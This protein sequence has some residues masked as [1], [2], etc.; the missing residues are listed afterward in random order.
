MKILS[1][2]LFFIFVTFSNL[3]FAKEIYKIDSSH[4]SVSWHANHFGFSKPSGKFSDVS[5]T[6]EIDRDNPQNNSVEVTIKTNSLTTGLEKFDNHLKSEDFFDEKNYPTITFKSSAISPYTKS[7][8]RIRGHL[9]L[10]GVDRAITLKVEMNKEGKNPI[11]QKQTI[12]F[13]ATAKINRSDFGMNYALPGISDEVEIS[14]EVEALLIEKTKD[15]YAHNF[16][17]KKS[18]TTSVPSWKVN[19]DQSNLKFSAYQNGSNIDGSFKEFDGEINFD[20]DN[21]D[22]SN[23]KVDIYTTSIS[24]PFTDI[25]E[26]VKD[27][28][29]LS[30]EL[31]RKATFES[32]RIYPASGPK[33]FKADG[34]LTIKDNKVPTTLEFVLNEYTK[35]TAKITGHATIKR[36]RFK[37]GPLSRLKSKNV[38]DRIDLKFEISAERN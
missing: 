16:M 24:M 23:I 3:S 37:I 12:G 18:K 38:D 35:T 32:T 27:K 30:T 15:D 2:V 21:L 17:H 6:I 9:N 1:V 13:S 28:E 7:K 5:G 4:A 25:L 34:Y 29:W 8:A 26:V 11:N 36:T 10:L 20:K 19:P 14:I 22:N 33:Q 31:F